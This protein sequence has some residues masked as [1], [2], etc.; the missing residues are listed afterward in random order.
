MVTSGLKWTNPGIL[1][2]ARERLGLTRQGVAREASRLQARLYAAFSEEQLAAWEEAAGEPE[3]QHLETLAEIYRCPVGYFLLE[4]APTETLPLSF[5]GL[6]KDKPGKL[7]PATLR[8]IHRFHELAQWTFHLT[9]SLEVRWHTSLQPMGQP[10]DQTVI[11][12]L[13]GNEKERFGWTAE[14]RSQLAESPENAFLWWR[15][16]IEGQGIFCFVLRLEPKEVRGASLRLSNLPFILVNHQDVEAAT[17]RIFTLLHEYAHLIAAHEGT[18]CDFRGLQGAQNPEPFAN[19]FAARMLISA[20]ELKQRLREVGQM[21]F[22]ESWPDT[23]LDD[24]RK[25]F[26]VSRDVVAITLEELRLAPGGFYESKRQQWERR[27]PWGRRRRGGRPTK[28]EIKLREIG[29]SLSRLVT[30]SVEHPSFPWMDVSHLLD[31]KVEQAEEFVRWIR[32]RS[33]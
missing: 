8:S 19:R 26:V 28:R 25:P 14:L 31:M 20:S 6:A 13:V 16:A 33:A 27:R 12:D 1:R 2:W 23:L 3:L 29:Y 10:L 32:S 11:D 7:S 17:G 21:G 5:R 18:V 15:T 22:R 4:S 30:S 24:I 9:E